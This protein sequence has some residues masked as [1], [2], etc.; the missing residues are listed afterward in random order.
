MVRIK[1][2]KIC[3]LCDINIYNRF[4][5]AKYCVSCTRV[6]EM[7]RRR[8]FSFMQKFKKSYPDIRFKVQIKIG[9][10]DGKKN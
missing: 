4:P 5:H 8:I 3:I 9:G 10:K 6:M 2:K 7:I 1:N